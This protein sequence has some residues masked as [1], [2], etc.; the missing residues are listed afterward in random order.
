MNQVNND[1]VTYLYITTVNRMGA[2]QSSEAPRAKEQVISAPE[3]GTSVE[4]GRIHTDGKRVE[5]ELI[6]VV[7][8]NID[9]PT[10]LPFFLLIIVIQHRLETLFDR[11]YRPSE[12]SD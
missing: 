5:H 9:Q 8:A 4:V 7:L 2:N 12:T 10:I 3:Q 6:H 1:K 11:R